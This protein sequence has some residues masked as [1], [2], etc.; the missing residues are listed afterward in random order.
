MGFTAY[1]KSGTALL[2]TPSGAPPAW[3]AL[4][5]GSGTFLITNGSL[6]SEIG[7]RITLGSADISASQEVTWTLNY[8]ATTL[9]GL[10]FREFGAFIGSSGTGMYNREAFPAVTFDGSNELQIQLTYQTF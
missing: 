1:G 3:M 4:G 7:T 2:W 6:V 8:G 5:S 10:Q 9:S